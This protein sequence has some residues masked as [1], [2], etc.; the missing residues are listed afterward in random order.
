MPFPH[1]FPVSFSVPGKKVLHR[2]FLALE[3]IEQLFLVG[4]VEIESCGD[5]LQE[6]TRSIVED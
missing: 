5:A 3:Q 6:E 4:R 2:S 1:C